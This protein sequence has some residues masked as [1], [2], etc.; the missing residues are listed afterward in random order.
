MITFALL[1]VAFV[2]TGL[3]IREEYIGTSIRNVILKSTASALFVLIGAIN[4]S[5][6]GDTRMAYLLLAGLV[7]GAFGDVFLAVRKLPERNRVLWFLWGLGAFLFGHLCYLFVFLRMIMP[8]TFLFGIAFCF[9]LFA[10]W[11]VKKLGCSFGGLQFPVFLYMFII[12]VMGLSAFN[13]ALTLGTMV[14]I[15]AA[16]AAALFMVSDLVLC[17][18]YFSNQERRWFD[19]LN[20][21]TY[22]CAQLIFAM[23]I[24]LVA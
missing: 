1:P 10:L 19:A 24:P 7:L 15:I 22:Y 6:S 4:L 14:S 2:A 8:P 12:S 20:L 23:L 17:F 5:L 3:F 18:M 9:A 11:G 21:S 13:A 16:V